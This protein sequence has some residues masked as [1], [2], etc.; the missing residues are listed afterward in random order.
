MTTKQANLR[1]G[2]AI[3]AS[4]GAD[5]PAL[6]GKA[7]TNSRQKRGAEAEALAG[8]YLANQGLQIIQRNFRVKGGEIDLICRDGNT[9][10][11]VEVRLRVDQRFGGA[12]ASVTAQ[13]Q[14][15][16]I[17]AARHWLQANGDVPCR[18]DCVL[19]DDLNLARIEWLRGA[20]SAD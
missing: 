11:F 9:V 7:D 16:L 14:R 17:I 4:V 3:S 19:L 10:V 12:A 5:D 8:K 20:F 18:F 13:K 6:A 2:N 15:R 1:A